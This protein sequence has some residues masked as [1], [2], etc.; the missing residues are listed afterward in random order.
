[1]SYGW[2]RISGDDGGIEGGLVELCDECGFDARLVVDE[3]SELLAAMVQLEHLLEHPDSD[4]RPAPETWS[5]REYVEHCHEVTQALLEYVARVT[6]HAA[7]GE[8]T[9]L[10]AARAAVSA[11]MLGLTAEEHAAELSGEYPFPVSV[12]WILRHLLHDLEHHV[13]DLRRGYARIALD[14]HEGP[15]TVQR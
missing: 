6:P 14:R 3:E 11:L 13:L 4:Q 1:M 5:A 9:N 15:H 7:P 10:G 8:I 12:T 2:R